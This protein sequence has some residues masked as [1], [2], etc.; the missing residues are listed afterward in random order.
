MKPALL[1][2]SLLLAACASN[3]GAPTIRIAHLGTGIQTLHLPIALA[4]TLGYFKAEGLNVALEGFNSGSKTL[5]ALTGGSV[6]VAGITYMQSIQMAAEGQR[7]RS[8]FVMTQRS[9]VALVVTP[10]GSKNVR[11]IEDLKGAVLG[12]PALGSPTHI[13]ANYLL[14]SH[15][16]APAD[17]ST[18]SIGVSASAIAAAESG[19]IDAAVFS[20]GDHFRLLRRNPSLTVLADT[21]TPEGMKAVFGTDIAPLGAV[22][23]RQEWLDRNPDS[24]RRL[25]RA[26]ARA[27]AWIASHS[28]EE[29]H[30]QLPPAMRSQSSEEDLQIIRWSL[31]TFTVAGKMPEGGPEAFKRILDATSDKVRTT[32]IDLASTWTNEF[33]PEPK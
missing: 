5:Q 33:L 23:A 31:P 8:F 16:V 2:L 14:L 25:A 28:P 19:R 32:P 24:A 22:A 6:D 9:G 26:L 4:D 29:I 21:S 20:A 10:S 13:I 3:K 15:G 11:R 27:Q 12:V 1:T 18:T 7:L 17:V 30:A